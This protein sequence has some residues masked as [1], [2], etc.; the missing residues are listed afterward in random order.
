MIQA[1]ETQQAYEKEITTIIFILQMRK[2]RTQCELHKA[3]VLRGLLFKPL[4]TFPLS[5]TFHYQ[6]RRGSGL[7][8]QLAREKIHI[9]IRA[10]M[11]ASG[12]SHQLTS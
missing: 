1:E 8:I 12:P 5:D 3:T 7:V 4:G 10:G 6:D 9:D 2:L 11:E